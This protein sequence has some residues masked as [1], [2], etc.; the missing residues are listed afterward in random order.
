MARWLPI[1]QD[2][3]L[4]ARKVQKGGTLRSSQPSVQQ[5]QRQHSKLTSGW[6]LRIS[7]IESTPTCSNTQR[8]V[9]P[10]KDS[11][12]LM[13]RLLP[14]LCCP[15]Q[16]NQTSWRMQIFWP[17]VDSWVSTQIHIVHCASPVPS[18]SMPWSLQLKTKK[19]K[20]WPMPYMQNGFVNL[21]FWH[22]STLMAGK[23]LLTNYHKNFSL[24]SI[25]SI[26]KSTL[27]HP[28]CNMQ[29][30]VFNKTIKKYL[31]SLINETTVDREN[32]L[33]ALML[34][35]NTSYHST[36]Y[37][38]WTIFWC[39]A[40]TTLISKSGHQSGAL[41]QVLP[42]R[43]FTTPTKTQIYCKKYCWV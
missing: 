37:I 26:L 1:P 20:L 31:A 9:S 15:C 38:I 13:P 17:N 11:K 34:A 10:V 23:S 14:F 35:Y 18:P 25:F 39:Q 28:Q 19:Q 27:A 7:G 21:V 41:W 3:P 24:Y 6:Q 40:S 2:C 42:N 29:V 16:I 4:L 33:P 8:P 22:K 5:T 30:K 43:T 36:I 12:S 32:L